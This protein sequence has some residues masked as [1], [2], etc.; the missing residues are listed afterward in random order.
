MR[1]PLPEKRMAKELERRKHKRFE[2]ICDAVSF[3]RSS[4]PNHITVATIVDI[5]PAGLSVL[6]F[7][8]QLP[9]STSLDLDIVLPGGEA[10]L[11]ELT[12]R[13]QWDAVVNGPRIRLFPQRQCGIVFC[14]LTEVQQSYVRSLIRYYTGTD[15]K[16]GE[17]T[18]D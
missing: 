15:V 1:C 17:R 9:P 8:E 7:S 14:D 10:L 5:S 2:L 12:G 18:G 16:E 4:R 11:P 3:I 13:I 6:H